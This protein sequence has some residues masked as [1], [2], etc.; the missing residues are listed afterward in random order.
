MMRHSIISLIFCTILLFTTVISADVPAYINYQGKV[1]DSLGIPLDGDYWFTF[2][3]WDREEDGTRKWH[4][5]PRSTIHVDNGLFSHELGSSYPMPSSIFSNPDNWLEITVGAETIEPRTRLVTVPYAYHAL[6]CDDWA[7][8]ATN[9]Y[10]LDGYVGVGVDD[11]K[12]KLEV[13]GVMRILRDDD[14]VEPG[15]G[16]GMEL[17]YDPVEGVGVI[18]VFERPMG[19][20]NFSFAHGSVGIGRK[21]MDERLHVN[22]DVKADNFVTK[23]DLRLKTNIEKL[24]NVLDKLDQIN[25]VTFEW[26]GLD[27]SPEYT[28]E[29]I[30]IGV[31]AQEVEKVF[32]EIVSTSDNDGYKSVSYN[33]LTAVLLEAVNELKAQNDELQERIEILEQSISEQ[34]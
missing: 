12:T 26:N 15:N 1:T 34:K 9:I 16:E 24:E 5:N 14:Y 32:P 3:I 13:A 18:D 31:I 27:Q 8:S 17:Y 23:S 30:N 25:G 33:Q 29:G 19:Y 21:T 20:R 11:P 10:R 7:D 6:N 22:G 4:S 28:N 2:S